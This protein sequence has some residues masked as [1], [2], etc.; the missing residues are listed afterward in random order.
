[1]RTSTLS[2][3]LT[4]GAIAALAAPAAYAGIPQLDPTWFASQLFWLVISFG[5]MLVLVRSAIAPSIDSVLTTRKEAIASAMREA[6]NYR[7]QA[8]KASQD[9]TAAITDAKGKAAAMTQE[10]QSQAAHRMAETM[11]ALDQELKTKLGKAETAVTASKTT[12][13]GELQEHA[14][15]LT[16]SIVEKLVGVSINQAD[17]L[18]VTRKVS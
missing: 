11:Q 18:N 15:N 2:I 14:A 17:A 6:E 10:V 3:S 7:N 13:M 8:N 5:F 12:A 16:K 4:A 9:M 1:M